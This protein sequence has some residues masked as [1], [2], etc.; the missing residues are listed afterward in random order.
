MVCAMI[1][2]SELKRLATSQVK[3]ALRE[4]RDA[5]PEMLR[6]RR[7]GVAAALLAAAGR[8]GNAAVQ[9]DAAR[10]LA[11]ALAALQSAASP[12]DAQVGIRRCVAITKHCT[13]HPF[14]GGKGGIGM[15][16]C[17]VAVGRDLE[18]TCILP[19]R[20]SFRLI[21]STLASALAALQSAASSGEG[22]V[23]V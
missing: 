2:R 13:T 11:S 9:V 20:V 3:A 5:M 8:T 23:R 19:L 4:L 17:W 14:V 12:G 15:H 7:S 6:G 21:Y 1:K 16:S 18:H 10:A 22:Q